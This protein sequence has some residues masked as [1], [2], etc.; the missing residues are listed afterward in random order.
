MGAR[1]KVSARSMRWSRAGALSRGSRNAA[2]C[3]SN[4]H[5]WTS[6]CVSSRSGVA[7]SLRLGINLARY[8]TIPRK[9]CKAVTSSGG[10][11]SVIALTL[12]GSGLRPV[13]VKT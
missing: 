8:V 4:Q 7:K 6:L 5:Q 1:D 13:A 2:L 11:M 12:A 3:W 9:H 10:G